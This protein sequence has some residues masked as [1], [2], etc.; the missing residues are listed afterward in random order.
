MGR[1]EILPIPSRVGVSHLSAN[2]VTTSKA[3]VARPSLSLPAYGL[4]QSRCSRLAPEDMRA[5]SSSLRMSRA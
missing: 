1:S 5:G 4:R 2:H 3:E